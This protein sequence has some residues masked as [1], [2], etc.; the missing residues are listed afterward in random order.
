LRW[1][2]GRVRTNY[3]GG[4]ERLFI[5]PDGAIALISFTALPALRGG[6]LVEQSPIVHYLAAERDLVI[7]DGAPQTGEGLLALGGPAFD[8]SSS[9]ERH[10]ETLSRGDTSC[11]SILAFQF[12]S[13]PG[14][15]KE[16]AEIGQL[17]KEAPI[18]TES[19][20]LAVGAD[21]TERAFKERAAGR[22]VLHLATHGFFRGSACTQPGQ[23]TRAVGGLS[24]TLSAPL[25][26]IAFENPLLLSGLAFAGA[27]RR[28]QLGDDEDDGIL[29]AEEIAGMNLQGT[30]WAVLSAC[31]TGL[32]TIRAGEGVFGL[33]RAFQ[34]AGVRTVIMSLWSVE[35]EATRQWMRALYEARLI[36]KMDTAESV[37]HAS[38]TVL[39]D[40]R[41]RGLSTH[42]FYWAAFVASGDWR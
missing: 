16:A 26:S 35:D 3:V 2:S 5:V 28:A 10:A 17:W 22:R 34:I 15:L 24:S 9:N 32:G 8:L 41:A 27:N 14:S 12:T 29:T 23:N 7:N 19:I 38:L 1:S 20:D 37:R 30:E 25:P 18:A 21:A 31:D 6:Y 42:P 40:R 4:A 11:R 36:K 13:L 33:R 39:N